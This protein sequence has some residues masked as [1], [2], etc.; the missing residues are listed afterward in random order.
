MLSVHGQ[1]FTPRAALISAGV[2]MESKKTSLLDV[3]SQ[4]CLVV[5]VMWNVF[6]IW[7]IK[8]AVNGLSAKVAEIEKKL[9]EDN[10]GLPGENNGSLGDAGDFSTGR[11]TRQTGDFVPPES[12]PIIDGISFPNPSDP[13][14]APASGQ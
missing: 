11:P 1:S 10:G 8:D 14:V 9:E 13:V 2:E 4:L 6:D 3:I 12:T 5:V 7:Q